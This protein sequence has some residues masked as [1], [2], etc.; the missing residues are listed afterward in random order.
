MYPA[1]WCGFFYQNCFVLQCLEIYRKSSI[2]IVTFPLNLGYWFD[3]V[4]LPTKLTTLWS[5]KRISEVL[6]VQLFYSFVLQLAPVVTPDSPE[7][8]TLC[9]SLKYVT[10]FVCQI[11]VVLVFSINIAADSAVERSGPGRQTGHAEAV[12]GRIPTAGSSQS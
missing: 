11:L 4:R 1:G 6:Y 9:G 12:Q 5:G 8:R 2:A 3:G 10:N 7:L